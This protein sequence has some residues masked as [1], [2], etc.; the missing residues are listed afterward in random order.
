LESNLV[1][2]SKSKISDTW[3]L[4]Y[5]FTGHIP[6][7][8]PPTYNKYTCSTMFTATLFIL[9]QSWKQSRCPLVEEWMEK[10]WC[11]YTMEYYSASKNNDFMKCAGKWLEPW[12]RVYHLEWGNPDTKEH[13]WYVLTDKWILV[14]GLDKGCW[15][16]FWDFQ[17]FFPQQ[18]IYVFFVLIF[19]VSLYCSLLFR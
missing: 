9:A 12:D 7:K 10:I 16:I 17:L 15:N 11:N 18:V 5:T 2:L 6:K 1:I 8:Y 13:T 3:L 19:C 4:R 14:H